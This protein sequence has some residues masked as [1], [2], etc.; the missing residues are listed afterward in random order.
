[1]RDAEHVCIDDGYWVWLLVRYPRKNYQAQV[2][3]RKLSPIRQR[4]GER[5]PK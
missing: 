4:S 2:N 1:M 3:R 5:G